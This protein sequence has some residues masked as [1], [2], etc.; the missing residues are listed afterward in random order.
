MDK[1]KEKLDRLIELIDGRH[2]EHDRIREEMQNK[3][4]NVCS[5]IKND[6][7]TY[8][9][10]LNGEIN[11]DFNRRHENIQG[12]IDKLDKRE[13]DVDALIKEAQAELIKQPK[14]EIRE[15]GFF[16]GLHRL[17]ISVLRGE[18]ISGPNDANSIAN[19][20]REYQKKLEEL[21]DAAQTKLCEIRIKK[22]K[23]VDELYVRVNDEELGGPFTQEDARLQEVKAK[24]NEKSDSKDPE[25]VKELIKIGRLALLTKQSYTLVKENSYLDYHINP[26]REVSLKS[27]DFE[28]RKPRSL[29]PSFTKKGELSL[30]FAFFDEGEARVLKEF[31]LHFEVEMRV[32]EK[33]HGKDTSKTL[34]K[35]LT[36]GSDKPI[37]LRST[38]TAS[39]TYCLRMKIVHQRMSTEW[40]DEAEFTPEF[41]DLCVWKEC[42]DNVDDNRKYS[43][44]EENVRIAT[45]IGGGLG[46]CTIIGN[47]PLP[48]NK[49]TSWNIKILKSKSNDGNNM[50]IG[51][52]PFNIDQNEPNN[53]YKC[54]WYFDCCGS[55]LWS[56]PPHYYWYPGKEYGPRKKDGEYV[57]TGVSIGVVMD[58]TKSELSFVLN[59][60]NYGVAFDGIPLNKPLVPCVL[61][62]NK[63]DSVELDTSEVEETVVDSSIPIP[64]NVTAKSI[65][66][67]SITLTWDAVGGASF[68]QIEV[69]GSR[70]WGG[71]TTN[72]FT[73]R[74]LPPETDHTIR[75]R[76]VKG[77]SV[78][79]WSEIIIGRTL[80]KSFEASW[81]K[82]CPDYVDEKM[83]YSVD[84]K[85]L[86][87]ATKNSNKYGNCIIIGNTPLPPNAVTPWSIKILKSRDNNGWGI[88]IGVAPSDINQNKHDN[89][90]KCGCYFDCFESK[91][92]SGPPH[93]CK[94]KEYGPRKR[95][96]EYVHIGD[97][98]NIFMDTTKGDLSFA[99]NGVNLGVAYEGIP[100]DKPLVPCVLLGGYKGDSVELGFYNVDNSINISNITATSTSWDSITLTWDAVEGASF[101][102]IEA[103]RSKIWDLSIENKISKTSL[104]PDTEHSFKVR[105]VRGNSVGEW[106]S[107]VNVKTEKAAKFGKCVWKECPDYVY[108]NRKYSVDEENPRIA[109]NT[110]GNDWSYCTII[111]STLIPLNQVISWSIKVLKSRENNGSSIYIGVAPSDIGQNE[112]Y[113]SCGW[114]FHCYDSMLWS[115]PP[116]KYAGK[117]YGPRKGDGEYV[118][119]GDIVCLMMDTVKGELSFV[120][121][122]VNLGVAY[123]EIPLDKPLVPCVILGK[124]KDSVELVV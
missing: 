78:S 34:T 44:D 103:V 17:C 47:T 28:E 92:S 102:Q 93:N 95:D 104:F 90:E 4:K 20:L 109:S 35:E 88:F 27:I 19:K 87:I 25:E 62:R 30:S 1:L 76:T 105:T 39:T 82:E 61:L 49:V 85:N 74:G 3:M 121:D 115:G 56:G 12:L 123:A 13:G 118:H 37:F 84:G 40:S 108:K 101:Y 16:Y 81:W 68:Y 41:K 107:I 83:K 72:T 60:V 22:Q 38:F 10:G 9:E 98:I 53:Y 46:F 66:W 8:E 116:H 48:L 110:N 77:N 94:N 70:S 96:G 33:G 120:L 113:K 42:P 117:E 106:S 57:H 11:N 31:G 119:T 80:E 59:G 21:K 64:S 24:L 55:T 23:E 36:L 111:G 75:V 73:K 71:S 45:K 26:E 15:S 99:V 124:Q 50:F 6:I 7:G 52:A 97:I 58:S 5:E 63:G 89:Y 18:N 54:G 65:T 29:I 86:R 43:V 122:G 67:D 32:W 91:L 114:Y 100:L 51:V 69:D 14:Y 112:N 2:V 79:K